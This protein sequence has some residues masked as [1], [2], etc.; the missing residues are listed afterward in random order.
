MNHQ[1]NSRWGII[2]IIV[3]FVA[4]SRLVP[5][6]LATSLFN[7][8]PLGG[9]ALFS[10]AYFNRRYM[11][12]LLPFVALWASN[13]LIDNL[14]FAKYYDGF[15]WFANPEVYFAF[16]LIV[17]MGTG[18]LKK[19]TVP[20]LGIAAVSSSLVFFI[21]TNFYVWLNTLTYPKTYEGFVAC[22]V[23]AIPF[24]WNTLV[25]DFLYVGV[26]F[27]GFELVKRYY[28]SLVLEKA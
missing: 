1:A 16:M 28:P 6:T 9:I 14:F 15:A 11:A 12:Y 4:M 26:L 22:Y 13:L 27:G 19:I 21:V 25:S 20:R 8:S 17:L 10:A 3:V 5:H 7:F 24:Y 18:L 23:A 2:A